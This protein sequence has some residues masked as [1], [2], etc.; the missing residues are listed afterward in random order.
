MR[1]A[2][3][4]FCPLP[5][6][7]TS[8]GRGFGV[9]GG[10]YF[11]RQS[12]VVFVIQTE[13]K[14]GPSLALTLAE[15]KTLPELYPGFFLRL[16]DKGVWPFENILFQPPSPRW[17]KPHPR[18][19]PEREGSLLAPSFGGG[20]LPVGRQGGGFWAFLKLQFHHLVA[21]QFGQHEF[22]PSVLVF[23]CQRLVFGYGADG[24]GLRIRFY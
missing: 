7:V 2:R 4:V 1:L 12:T 10:Y 23:E 13:E 17:G 15:F 22:A 3:A 5:G 8:K 19:L 24:H 9:F 18:P 14:S 16:N 6:V 11:S 20:F 21:F